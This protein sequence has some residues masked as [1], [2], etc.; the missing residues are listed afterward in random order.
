[1]ATNGVR[2]LLGMGKKDRSFL[3]NNARICLLISMAP[4]HCDVRKQLALAGILLNE[5]YSH[6]EKVIP[7]CG[8]IIDLEPALERL[9]RTGRSAAG[10]GQRT[11]H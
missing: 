1:M 8:R 5:P 6:Y 7:L 2:L 11:A 10:K 3:R 9:L 4:T